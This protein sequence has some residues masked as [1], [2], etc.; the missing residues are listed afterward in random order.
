I[1]VSSRS[2]SDWVTHLSAGAHLGREDDLTSLFAVGPVAYG[3][4]IAL[5]SRRNGRRL[6]H[7][8]S[9]PITSAA[10]ARKRS[11]SPLNG[12][13]FWC[14]AT[15]LWY[16]SRASRLFPRRSDAIATKNQS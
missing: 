13:S 11:M 6:F 14:Q 12:C 10:S 9:T 15:A 1:C 2:D 8:A 3:R 7:T 5:A 4:G 16:H